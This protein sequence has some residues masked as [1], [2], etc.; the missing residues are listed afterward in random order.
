MGAFQKAEALFAEM[1]SSNIAPDAFF[2]DRL[3]K[4]APRERFRELLAEMEVARV[5]PTKDLLRRVRQHEE[6]E[7]RET[8]PLPEGW[9]E[10]Q[11]A[12]TGLPYY[13]L[14]TDPTASVT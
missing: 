14:E 11:D 7:R 1:R 3:L 13:W 9:C 6:T 5:Q 4:H 2:Y 8:P 12:A 10:A